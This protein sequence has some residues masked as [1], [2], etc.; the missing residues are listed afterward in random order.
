MK[1]DDIIFGDQLRPLRQ[2]SVSAWKKLYLVG[3]DNCV[4]LM[5]KILALQKMVHRIWAWSGGILFPYLNII[6]SSYVLRKD[7]EDKEKK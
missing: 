4:V 3:I 1:F 7:S 5:P 6:L 2:I